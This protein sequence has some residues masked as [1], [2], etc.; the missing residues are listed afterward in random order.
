MKGRNLLGLVPRESVGQSVLNWYKEVPEIVE[1]YNRA[2]AGEIF[3][4][5]VEVGG[6]A[7]ETWYSPIKDENGEV[8]GVIGV[9]TDITERKQAEKEI[10]RINNHLQIAIENMPNAYILWDPD[11]RIIE[12]SKSAERIFGYSKEEILGKQAVDFIVPEDSRNSV[13]EVLQKL[14]AGEAAD[15]S[16]EN[17]NIRKDGQAI[18]CQWYNTPLTDEDGKVFAILMLAQDVTE[19]VQAA[20]TLKESEEKYRTTLDNMLEGCQIIG[21][22]WR[23]LYVNDAVIRHGHKAKEAL[24]GHT[25]ME[26]YPDI[27]DTEMF[28]AIR[29][30]MEK[31]IPHRM[32]NEF[33]FSD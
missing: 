11:F 30:C 17:N 5:I 14:R 18:S 8:T 24:L 13:E 7:F 28:A 29:R 9:S 25:M 31:R 2:L 12:W 4:S 22:D 20:K 6:S 1:H 26:V 19:R 10:R 21:Y 16:E 3:T 23:Y 32:E 15:F 27:E 33:T